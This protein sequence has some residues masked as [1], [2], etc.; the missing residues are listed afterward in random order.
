[1]YMRISKNHNSLGCEQPLGLDVNQS[2]DAQYM[3]MYLYIVHVYTSYIV[4]LS[5]IYIVNCSFV[6]QELS[7]PLVSGNPFPVEVEEEELSHELQEIIHSL[8]SVRLQYVHI[9]VHVYHLHVNSHIVFW[10]S[11]V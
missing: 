4:L 6:E 10:S 3:Y 8:Q 5:S 2:P 9:H 1:M 7:A 11:Y